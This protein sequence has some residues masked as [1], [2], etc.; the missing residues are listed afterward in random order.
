MTTGVPFP[1]SVIIL[2]LLNDKTDAAAH[3]LWFTPSL[4]LYVF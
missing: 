3:S 1:S 4:D 2:S